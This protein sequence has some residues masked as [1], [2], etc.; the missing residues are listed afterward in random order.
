MIAAT[1]AD[2]QVMRG[3]EDA[4]ESLNRLER[5]ARLA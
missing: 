3:L 1:R 2:Q 5:A 4:E